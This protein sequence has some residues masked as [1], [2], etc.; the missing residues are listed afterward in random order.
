DI[1]VTTITKKLSQ[2]AIDFKAVQRDITNSLRTAE[3]LIRQ[4]PIQAR[5]SLE[6]A[7]KQLDNAI[8]KSEF[9][10]YTDMKTEKQLLQASSQLHEAR[11][12]LNRGERGQ[13]SEIIHQVRQTVEK[14]M[15]QP[16]EQRVKHFVSDELMR[17][18][19]IPL[20]KQLSRSIEEPLQTLEV[21]L[22]LEI[23]SSMSAA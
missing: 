22:L 1:L 13:A 3:S 16:S 4:A 9:M 18:E 8:L 10:L 21:N 7:I 12:L 11:K 2:A 15:F 14:I 6:S 19:E 20:A 17:L 23:R 5:P